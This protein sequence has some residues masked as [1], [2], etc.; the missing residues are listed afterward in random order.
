MAKTESKDVTK[1]RSQEL[2]RGGALSPFEEMERMFQS[3][4]GQPWWPRRMMRPF[5][6]EF[7][8]L[9]AP[10]EGRTPK[11]DVIERD[12]EVLV[13]AELPGVKKEDLDVSV[14]DTS[15]TIR[16]STRHEEKKEEG[17]YYRREM[18]RGEF[19]RTLGLPAEVDGAK[20]KASFKDGIL[21]LTVPKVVESRRH[22][23]SVS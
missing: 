2:Q 4:W 16:A 1:S 14:S 7:G 23:V 12:K 21:E 9:P 6:G 8:N 11:V 13:K 17:E 3:L 18:S 20:A 22:K 19:V 15:V 10:F 5:E